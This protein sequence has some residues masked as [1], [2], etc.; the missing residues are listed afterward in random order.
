MNVVLTLPKH[1]LL[2]FLSGYKTAEL[3][4]SFP[5]KL[6]VGKEGFFIIEKGTDLC[7][8]WC[9]VSSIFDFK[10]DSLM[11]GNTLRAVGV[12]ERWVSDY[13]ESSKISYVWFVDKVVRF[14]YPIHRSYFLLDHNPQS[15]AYAPSFSSELYSNY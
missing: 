15:F 3:R 14:K 11:D 2:L 9:R 7:Y 6:N 8:A 4:K 5:T 10:R 1:L 13:R 12:S